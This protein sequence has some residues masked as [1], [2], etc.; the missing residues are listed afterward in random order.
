MSGVLLVGN[1]LSGSRMSR[2]VCED[3]AEHLAVAGWQVLTT[4]SKLGRVTRLF[5]MTKT[6]WQQRHSYEVAQVD[7]FS[8]PSFLWAEVVTWVLRQAK[9][10]FILTLHGGNL[11]V[12]ARN[13]PKRVAR[14]LESAVAVT[15][16]SVYLLEQMK[17]YRR[18]LILL[19]N[20]IDV[21]RYSFR[22]RTRPQPHLVWLRAFH[23]IYNP[24]LVPET[25][26]QLVDEFPDIKVIMAGSDKG[27]GSLQATQRAAHTH[28]I[29]ERI[30]FPG[31]V[32]KFDVPIWLNK[33]DIFIN[34]ANVDNT[35][36]SV[37][38]AM[39]CGLCVISTNVGGIPYM[40][41]NEQDALLVKPNDPTAMAQAVKRVLQIDNL[42]QQLSTTARRK[43]EA[44]D[45]ACI[46]PQWEILLHKYSRN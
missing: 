5:D 39:A 26:V 37:M 38:E 44:M 10:P 20:P 34:T 19:P 12:F 14:L 27:D 17:F 30:E 41:K 21:S 33:G 6:T 2:G 7:V 23:Q 8:G 29:F 46:L 25:V 4:S 3:L 42:S 40:L 32:K 11:P 13:R 18:E 43:V 9:K 24:M 22:L 1:F 36:I 28:G 16:P 15:V 35:P 31:Q 45:W